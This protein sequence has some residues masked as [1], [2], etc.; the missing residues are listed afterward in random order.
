MKNKKGFT[1]IELLIV[2]AIIGI[3]ASIVLVSLGSARTK[4]KTASYK[5]SISSIIPALILCEDSALAFAAYNNNGTTAVCA[6]STS[7][8]PPLSVNGN[9]CSAAP[10]VAPD[11]GTADDDGTFTLDVSGCTGV[12]ANEAVAHCNESGCTFSAS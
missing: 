2:I 11:N 3:L 10:T 6:G 8:W 7:Y 4:A 5:S 12:D 1:L 9:P